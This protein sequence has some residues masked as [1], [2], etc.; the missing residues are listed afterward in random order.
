MLTEPNYRGYSIEAYAELSDGYWDA[1]VRIRQLIPDQRLRVER[2]P[3]RKVT[4]VLAEGRAAIW[5]KRWVDQ[6]STEREPARCLA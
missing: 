5:A 3:C 6:H 2:I 4:A 1:I